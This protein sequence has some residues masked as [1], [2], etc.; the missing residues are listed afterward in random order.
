[1]AEITF[2]TSSPAFRPKRHAFGDPE[3]DA[4]EDDLVDGLRPLTCPD[5]SEV[6]DALSH[7]AEH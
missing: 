5:R 6:R 3:V 7:R 2:S 1:M 4:R